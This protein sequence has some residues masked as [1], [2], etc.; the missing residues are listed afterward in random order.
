MYRIK[1]AIEGLTLEKARRLSTENG[2]THDSSE[3]SLVVPDDDHTMMEFA[4]LSEYAERLLMNQIYETSYGSMPQMMLTLDKIPDA[5]SW[6]GRIFKDVGHL[7][8]PSISPKTELEPLYGAPSRKL[9]DLGPLR[10]VS[11]SDA[12]MKRPGDEGNQTRP[13]VGY[14]PADAENEATIGATAIVKDSD[15]KGDFQRVILFKYTN[16]ISVGLLKV[17]AKFQELGLDDLVPFENTASDDRRHWVFI[18]V[19]PKR[20]GET[21]HVVEEP[22]KVKFSVTDGNVWMDI[23]IDQYKLVV[24]LGEL[25]AKRCRLYFPVYVSSLISDIASLRVSVR[26]RG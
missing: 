5:H 17:R 12:M 18:W 24:D 22:K 4:K 1:R 10:R 7:L 15:S 21:F 20:V 14:Y 19:V 26:T 2:F 13:P 6:E 9:G 16:S 8:V 11:L 3:I 23:H 25:K